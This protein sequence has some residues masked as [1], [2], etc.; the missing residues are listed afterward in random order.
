[1]EYFYISQDKR[2]VHAPYIK[3][4]YDRYQPNLF[5]PEHI[6]RI[7]DKNVVYTKPTAMTDH[8]DIL[9]GPILLI[10]QQMRRVLDAYDDLA[11]KMFFILDLST[12][13]GDIYYAPILAKES[14]LRIKE[15]DGKKHLL[16]NKNQKTEKSIRRPD[17]E[18]FRGGLVID[19][20]V[21]ESLLRRRL[22][23]IDYQRL[24]VE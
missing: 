24:E 10:S 6:H 19:M 7:P 14:C 21:A 2:F 15:V 9:S 16:F 8:V 1:M 5:C 3:N 22:K 23:G 17:K 13:Q 12:D 11:Y 18:E 20:M 4:F